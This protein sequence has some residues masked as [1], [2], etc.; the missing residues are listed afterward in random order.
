MKTVSAGDANRH[1]SHVLREVAQGETIVVTSRGR[2]VAE[3]VPA[4]TL[5]RQRGDARAALLERLQ[6]QAVSGER[7]WTRDELYATSP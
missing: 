6:M 7:T 3:I 1:F 2:P 4:Q 5:Q